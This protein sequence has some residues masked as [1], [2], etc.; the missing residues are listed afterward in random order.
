MLIRLKS[1]QVLEGYGFKLR[2]Q[3]GK[4]TKFYLGKLDNQSFGYVAIDILPNSDV[5]PI[6]ELFVLPELRENGYGSHLLLGAEELGKIKNY[7][8]ITLKPEPLPNS[9][10]KERLVQ[11]YRDR[12]Y[13]IYSYGEMEK[14]L[15]D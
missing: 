5:M 3:P 6:Y 2:G 7:K 4:Y 11:W 13:Q 14:L 8:K 10:S 12:G 1:H 9:I 15:H